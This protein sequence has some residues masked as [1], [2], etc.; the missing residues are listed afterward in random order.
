MNKGCSSRRKTTRKLWDKI[1]VTFI[2]RGED[3][4]I[5]AG[6]EL[7]NIRMKNGETVG[8]Y[9]ARAWWCVCHSLRL[10]VSPRELV[11]HFARGLNGKFPKVHGILKTQ[12]GKSEIENE[13]WDIDSF[14]EVSPERNEINQNTENG[15]SS[16]FDINNV[17]V[18][19]ENDN[20]IPLQKTSSPQTGRILLP[21]LELNDVQ[22]QIHVRRSERLKSKQMSV[23]LTN[24][25]PD[26]Y[27]EAKK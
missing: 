21:V 6:N 19:I 5:D 2:G 27:F 18:E 12:R 1:R 25:V 10:D 24:N 23:H 22:S 9:I 14:F 3:R 11:Y 8:D 13:T 20:S 7:K 15:V 16:N 17:S 26:S 4:K